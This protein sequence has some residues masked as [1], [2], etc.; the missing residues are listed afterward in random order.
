MTVPRICLVGAANIDLVSFTLRQP[1]M[2]ETLHG[3]SFLLGYGGK[4][5]NQAVAAAKLGAHCSLVAKL[6]HD[7]FGEGYLKHLGGAGVDVSHVSQTSQ[8]F[9]GTAAIAVDPQG[10][11][12][13]IVVAGANGL[14][15]PVD[16]EAAGEVL[17]TSNVVVCQLEVPVETTL[18]AL[19]LACRAGVRTILNPAPALPQFPD[20]LYAATDVFCPNEYEAFMLTGKPVETLSDAEEVGR[21]LLARGPRAVILT[22]GERGSLLVEEDEVL[23]VPAPQVKAMDSTGAGDAYIGSLAFSIAQGKMLAECMRFATR[24]ASISVQKAGTQASYPTWEELA[25]ASS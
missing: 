15:R 25:A 4:A 19:E 8:A 1:A 14:L 22:L 18:A 23:H 16:V 17:S 6:G 7:V 20:E 12:A 24:V 10:R 9:S 21:L 2:G 13:I 5:A 3:T 11:N